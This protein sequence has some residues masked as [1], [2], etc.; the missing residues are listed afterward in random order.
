M[1]S[2]PHDRLLGR[3]A[4]LFK[5]RRLLTLFER[6]IGSY[7]GGMGQG[8]PIGSLTL[9]HLANFY[10]G[11]FD[12]FIKE[13][14]RFTGYVRYMDDMALWADDQRELRAALEA[15]E[16]FLRDELGLELK[17]WPYLNRTGHGMDFL[18]LRQ[19]L[20]FG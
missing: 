16:G 2:I 3:L 6:V 7:R 5:D 14:L 15:G 17:P 18:V 8:L 19:R 13:C 1:N 20:N 11:W 10:L 4:R 12:R 9:Q